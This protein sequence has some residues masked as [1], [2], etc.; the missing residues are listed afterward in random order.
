MIARGGNARRKS[1]ALRT[2][3]A[4]VWSKTDARKRSRA[5][6]RFEVW[7]FTDIHRSNSMRGPASSLEAPKLDEGRSYNVG[8]AENTEDSERLR[9][10]TPVRRPASKIAA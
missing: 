4:I 3:V 10:E 2:P 1:A 9:T 6:V 5:L 8:S 7:G